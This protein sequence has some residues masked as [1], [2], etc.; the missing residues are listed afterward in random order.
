MAS[1]EDSTSLVDAVDPV[2]V[3][4]V[5]TRKLSIYERLRDLKPRLGSNKSDSVTALIAAFLGEVPAR[6]GAI[7][8]ILQ[9]PGSNGGHVARML[10]AGAGSS[11]IASRWS[12][13][14][15]GTYALHAD[16]ASTAPR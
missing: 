15:S 13:S 9:R 3:S 14:A 5:F 6:K 8:D 10:D 11:P 12:R 16:Q 1:K 4:P 2:P 7:I